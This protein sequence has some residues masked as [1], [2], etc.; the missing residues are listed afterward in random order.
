MIADEIIMK[1][2][3]NGDLGKMSILFERYHVRLYNFFFR[4]T[5]DQSLSEDLT[6]NVF[7]RIIR[8]R[9]SFKGTSSFKSWI[10][11]IAR[12]AKNDHF[13]NRR[14]T[15]L[16]DGDINRIDALENNISDQIEAR[17]NKINLEKAIAQLPEDQKEILLLTRFKKLKYQQ[18]AEMLGTSEGAI[19]VKVH[20]A[21]KQLRKIYFKIDAL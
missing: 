14:I 1:Q 3:Q 16:D 6:Q 8:Y 20:R 15:L 11:Q 21:I 5:Y 18:V 12:N 10:F 19:K 17:E 2:V 4:M 9:Q 7:E 13:R